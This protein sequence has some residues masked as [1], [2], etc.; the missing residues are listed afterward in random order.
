VNADLSKNF[1]VLSGL[2]VATGLEYR[3]DAFGINSG[4]EASYRNYDV[5]SGAAAGA[6]VF[7]G[8]RNTIGNEKTRK[9]KSN[10]FRP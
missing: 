3:I 1:D 5:N 2:N 9:C 4:E 10:L 8:F 6:Q 7:A